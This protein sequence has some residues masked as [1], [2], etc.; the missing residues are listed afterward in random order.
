ML[1]KRGLEPGSQD[2][3][4]AQ[5]TVF[6]WVITGPGSPRPHNRNAIVGIYH[7]TC[8]RDL[9]EQLQRF[10]ELEELPL[11]SRLTPQET[12]CVRH[13][14]KTTYKHGNQYVVRLPFCRTPSFSDSRR[15]AVSRLL[16]IERRPSKDPKLAEAYVNFMQ[17]FINLGHMEIIPADTVNLTAQK[18]SISLIIPSGKKMD[19]KS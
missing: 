10:C 2:M 3:P 15:T 5:P 12:K 8:Q 18:V 4:M 17:E 11:T 14:Q 1:I 6:G 19:H 9:S 16:G 7:S 13:F